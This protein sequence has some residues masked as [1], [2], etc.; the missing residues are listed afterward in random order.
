[1]ENSKVNCQEAEKVLNSE[2][3]KMTMTIRDYYPE[4]SP[5]LEEM[6]GTISDEKNLEITHNQLKTYSESLNSLLTRYILE[7]PISSK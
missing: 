6:P 1:M 3:L 5:F 7:H 2:I 4:L